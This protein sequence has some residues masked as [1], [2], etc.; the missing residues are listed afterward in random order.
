VLLQLLFSMDMLTA[1]V[2]TVDAA[3]AP[4]LDIEDLSSAAVRMAALGY[5]PDSESYDRRSFKTKVRITAPSMIGHR[6][7]IATPVKHPPDGTDGAAALMQRWVGA[8]R[9]P[10]MAYD[11]MSATETANRRVEGSTDD[12]LD[13]LLGGEEEFNGEEFGDASL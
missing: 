4:A 7:T 2:R 5:A 3:G 12:A 10:V 11:A 6:M 8:F 13:E 1:R 9:D